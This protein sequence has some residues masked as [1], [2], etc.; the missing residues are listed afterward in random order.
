MT[1]QDFRTWIDKKALVEQN[2][3]V[4]VVVCVGA[5]KVKFSRTYYHPNL[6][7]RDV[8][9]FGDSVEFFQKMVE[10]NFKKIQLVTDESM[11]ELIEMNER[12]QLICSLYVLFLEDE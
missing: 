2:A 10:K 5:V 1:F 11:Y 6:T 8:V 12:F 3:V 7:N 4:E 9:D